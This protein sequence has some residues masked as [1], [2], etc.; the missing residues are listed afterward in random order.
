MKNRK[1]NWNSEIKLAVRKA[2][3]G[4]GKIMLVILNILIT[5]ILIAVLTGI[6]VGCAFTIYIKNYVD[7]T[8]DISLFNITASEGTTS[9]AIYRYEFTDRINREGTAVLMEGER[10]VGSSSQEYVTYDRI[11][12][13]MINAVI[14]IEDKRF[15][16][17]EGVDWKRTL[18]AG[19]NFFIGFDGSYGG[20]TLTQQLIKN[21]TGE[22]DY[23]IQRKVQEIFWAL[24]LET[25]KDKEEILELYLNIANFGSARCDS[26]TG[27]VSPLRTGGIPCCR[28]NSG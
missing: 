24:D 21:I 8:V 2:F 7:T 6:I 27:Q 25:K 15:K 16:T 4:L 3:S 20:S 19:V 23:S 5:L 22:D 28:R 26:D 10:I 1:I 17:H 14:A 18:G 9:S 13:N 11:P 12:E